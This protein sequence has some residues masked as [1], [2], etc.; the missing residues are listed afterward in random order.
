MGIKYNIPHLKV[1]HFFPKLFEQTKKSS[2]FGKGTAQWMFCMH[3]C[4]NHL[5]GAFAVGVPWKTQPS[6]IQ[7][8]ASQVA[9]MM[10]LW[11]IIAVFRSWSRNFSSPPYFVCQKLQK[12]MKKVTSKVLF[13]QISWENMHFCGLKKR[14]S[15]LIGG[16]QV[17]SSKKC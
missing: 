1:K 6:E 15:F 8:N 3:L 11:K 5:L 9:T 13:R 4:R 17:N 14:L 7:P 10:G 12:F 16:I 2:S